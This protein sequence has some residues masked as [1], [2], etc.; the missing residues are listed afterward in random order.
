MEYKNIFRVRPCNE[1]TIDE[2]KNGYLWFSRPTSFKYK[3]D[4]NIGA[5]VTDTEAIKNGVLHVCPNFPF[6]EYYK[7]MSYTGICC[8]TRK[9][10]TNKQMKHFPY[11][12]YAKGIAIEF[13]KGKLE[14]FFKEHR[15]HP[16]Y[17]CFNK[18]I[19]SEA[20]TK[21]DTCDE[22]S[23]LWE[24]NE[25]FKKYKTL[26][27]IIHEHPREIDRF[28]RILLTRLHNRYKYQKEERIILGGCNIPSHNEDTTGYQIP[29]PNET[30]VKIYV[31]P[32]VS[33]SYRE[34]LSSIQTIKD[35]LV[36]L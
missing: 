20:P 15:K 31:Y 27:G 9:L 8:F 23:I 28:V 34:K 24:E 35:K 1:N 10:P 17:P 33:A 18:V 4:S 12:Q 29:V 14:A 3:Y 6:D 19:Y 13:D 16:I 26:S 2:L 5:F 11:C 22:W 30:I 7:K 36:F 32:K 21:L 25:N